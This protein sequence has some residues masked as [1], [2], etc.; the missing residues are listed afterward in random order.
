M[1]CGIGGIFMWLAAWRNTVRRP[2]QSVFTVIIT[3]ISVFTVVMVL[4]VFLMAKGGIALSEQRL[5]AD[6]MVLPAGAEIDG[7]HT[8][9]TA[10]PA[11][12]YMP[13]AI[14][15]EIAAVKG[16][17]QATPQFFTQT[18]NASCCSVS[19][20]T[21]LVGF[22]SDSDF[23]LAPY[24]AEQDLQRLEDD[25]VIV[26]GRMEAFLGNVVSILGRPFK[27]VGTL[28]STGSGMDETIF[29]NIDVARELARD[30]PEFKALGADTSPQ[31]LVSAVL[32]KTDS[33]VG[34][35]QVINRIK[36]LNL[37]IQAVSTTEV[38]E[39]VRRQ[40]R[41]VGQVIWG[42]GAA[43][44]VVAALSLAGRFN[45]LAAERKREIGL[46][47]AMGVQRLQIF[48]LIMA[49]ALIMAVAGGFIG[50]YLACIFAD[51][52][53]EAI[54]AAFIMPT[55]LWSLG[56]ALKC[57]AAGVSVS[58]LMGAAAS[59]YPAWKSTVVEPQQAISQGVLE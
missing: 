24:F 7:S 20:A 11:N 2:A 25:Q 40:M 35:G 46:M 5:G 51:P 17:S 1:A 42:L 50:S 30:N 54:K 36:N 43:V 19:T 27:I 29:M 14:L 26:G 38:V 59:F 13:A 34:S 55:G 28:Y 21:R 48:Q 44:L 33:G 12:I 16:V 9:F 15:P 8:L 56:T 49:E 53:V 3:A 32:I 31:D 52:L 41:A 57:G 58:V 4:A 6:V 18:L 10:R 45:A 22:D 37:E 47:R 23:I 39:N